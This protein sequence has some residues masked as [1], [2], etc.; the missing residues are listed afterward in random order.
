M[1]DAPADEASIPPLLGI[2]HPDYVSF[3]GQLDYAAEARFVNDNLLDLSH[4][5]FLH[6]Q[7]FGFSD[8]W[9]RER[10]KVTERGKSVRSERWIK[11]A[12]KFGLIDE[13]EPRVDTYVCYD[14]FVPGILAF[15]AEAFPCGSADALK[16]QSPQL[17]KLPEAFA[18]HAVTPLTEK[19]ARYFYMNGA[20]RR[21]NESKYD[22]A[23]RRVTENAF[24]EDKKMIEAQQRN[25]DMTPG[26]RFV[27]TAADHGAILF[28]RLLERL[29]REESAGLRVAEPPSPHSAQGREQPCP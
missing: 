15:I 20:H 11:S 26:W 6:A 7:S 5:G 12:G 2:D 10:P 24:A 1:G 18:T 21:G 19:T 25:L 8:I 9:G 14:F 22:P 16:G 4:V 28:N 17:D 3:H 29:C 27:P 23:A 13:A